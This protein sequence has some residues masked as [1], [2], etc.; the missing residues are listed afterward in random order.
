MN[1]F[2]TRLSWEKT[3]NTHKQKFDLE[4]IINPYTNG[5][6][7]INYPGAEG[8]I[9]GYNEKY[10]KL[11]EYII[12]QSLAAVVRLPNPYTFGFGWDMNL[13]Q[14][15]AYVL[16]QSKNICNSND[17]I[18][19]LM[20]FSAGAGAIASIAWEYPQVKKILLM[21]PAPNVGE[22]GVTEGLGQYKGEVYVVVGNGDESLGLDIGQRFI[23]AV[24]NAS[25]K[26]IFVIP[27]CDHQFKGEVN[28]RIVSEAPF[29]AFSEN[30]KPKFPDPHGGIKLYD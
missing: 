3:L 22:Q 30:N 18:I 25:K 7:I 4:L 1:S 9:D 14:A 29:Y 26:E 12:S 5:K 16:E 6:I 21:E 8:S 19:Y 13:R 28:G 10:R 23:D 2:S 24:V 11:A 15:L 20:G 17:P 27:N